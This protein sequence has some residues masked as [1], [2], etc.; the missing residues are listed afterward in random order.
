MYHGV[1]WASVRNICT[2]MS[3]FSHIISTLMSGTCAKCKEYISLQMKVMPKKHDDTGNLPLLVGTK[4]PHK[5]PGYTSQQFMGRGGMGTKFV[6][7]E[8]WSWTNCC[9]PI[10]FLEKPLWWKTYCNRAVMRFLSTQASN[11]HCS[12]KYLRRDE[13][14]GPSDCSTACPGDTAQSCGGPGHNSVYFVSPSKCNIHI[15]SYKGA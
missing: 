15:L 10:Q 2:I 5:L 13:P 11:C 6:H 7:R 1:V 4:Y 9:P 8:G 3:K 12:D 14:S